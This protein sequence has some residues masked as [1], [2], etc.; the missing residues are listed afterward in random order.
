MALSSGKSTLFSNSS[1]IGEVVWTGTGDEILWSVSEDDGST[2]L[3]VGD[4]GKSA[5]E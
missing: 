1:A 5:A 2:S 3:V 4:A